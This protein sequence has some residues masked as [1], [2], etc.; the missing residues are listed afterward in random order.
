[1]W[2]LYKTLNKLIKIKEKT[3][4]NLKEPKI[5]KKTLIKIHYLTF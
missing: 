1:M 4:K 2:Q 5:L 3:I